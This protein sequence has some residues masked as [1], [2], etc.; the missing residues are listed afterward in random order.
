MSCLASQGVMRSAPAAA[1]PISYS[2]LAANAELTAEVM[3][4][5]TKP[6]NC[7]QLTCIFAFGVCYSITTKSRTIIF[8][9]LAGRAAERGERGPQTAACDL[10]D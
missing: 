8:H 7:K 1:D 5:Q 6:A 10:A 2:Y 4:A 9:V 3:P